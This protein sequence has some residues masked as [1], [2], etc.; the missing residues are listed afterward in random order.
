MEAHLGYAKHDPVGHGP[1]NS[2]NDSIC[3]MLK[4]G[5]GEVELATP[6]K[7]N[8]TFEMQLIGKRRRG[9]LFLIFR[10]RR[11]FQGGASPPAA[12]G[13]FG[14]SSSRIDRRSIAGNDV[15]P[16]S[17]CARVN[18]PFSG[19]ISDGGRRRHRH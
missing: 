18:T 16:P 5:H 1:G 15:T 7:C 14:S 19:S 3:K 9:R 8:G 2:H 4:Y 10:L 12:A 13:D 11:R 6:R 17:E